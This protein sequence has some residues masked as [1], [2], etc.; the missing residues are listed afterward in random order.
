MARV[1]DAVREPCLEDFD[2]QELFWGEMTGRGHQTLQFLLE[3]AMETE[4]TER[5]GY[6]P[7]QRDPARHTDYRNGYYTRHLDTEW[8]PLVD[9]KVPRARQGGG[10]H[11]KI[12]ENYQRRTPGINRLVLE[13]F[14]EG[15]ATRRVGPILEQLLGAGVSATTVS[16]IARELDHRAQQWHGRCLKGRQYCYLI[17]DGV[18]LRRKGVTGPVK[19]VCLTVYGITKH[20][21]REFVAYRMARGESEAEWTLLLEDM[22]QRELEV[23]GLKLAVTDGAQGLINALQFVFPRLPLQRC[24][25]HKLRNV[26]NQLKQ[27][28]R[29]ECLRQAARIYQADTR[30]AAVH[31]FREWQEQWESVA[32]KA[33]QCLAKDIEPLL[34]FFSLPAAHRKMMRTTNVIERQ[35]REVRRRTNP[36]TCFTN[37]ASANRI[38]YAI[39]THANR[40]WA[41][42]PLKQFTQ[43]T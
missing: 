29:E 36:M 10:A 27:S 6:N 3:K 2:I 26:A 18:V 37:E 35:F 28:Q 13:M 5:L 23:E 4:L 41:K 21:Q 38:I 17:L 40:R 30:R 33:V 20:G 15:T 8:G 19:C 9:L 39:F 22:R 14:V 1:R 11:S 32:P 25:A 43:K 24:W 34:E 12:F 16:N 7:Y 42:S 31:H